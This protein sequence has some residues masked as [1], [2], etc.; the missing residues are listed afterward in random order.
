MLSSP[1]PGRQRFLDLQT[2]LK[3]SI[4]I[5]NILRRRKNENV[6]FLMKRSEAAKWHTKGKKIQLI[7][8]LISSYF[9]FFIFLHR[10]QLVPSG[11][12]VGPFVKKENIRQLW[13]K[14]ILSFIF[15]KIPIAKKRRKDE[16]HQRGKMLN[17]LHY[18]HPAP[19]VSHLNGNNESAT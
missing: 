8:Q 15:S 14:L 16:L 19:S 10:G 11:R 17:P 12:K 3:K 13:D 18:Q 6:F 9:F 2:F 4:R 7:S 1:P 5:T